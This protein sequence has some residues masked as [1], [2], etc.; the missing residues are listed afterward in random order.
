[1]GKSSSKQTTIARAAVFVEKLR[2]RRNKREPLR[3][4]QRELSNQ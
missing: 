4:E 1:L 2:A 3:D